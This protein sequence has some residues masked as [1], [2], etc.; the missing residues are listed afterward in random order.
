MMNAAMNEWQMTDGERLDWRR[1]W[2]SF[3]IRTHRFAVILA[4]LT[5]LL[6]RRDL[7]PLNLAIAQTVLTPSL[8][9]SA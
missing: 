2:S 5:N 6:R 3:H 4:V 9:S 8:P 1:F 7:D